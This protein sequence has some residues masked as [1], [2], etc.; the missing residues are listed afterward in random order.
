MSLSGIAEVVFFLVLIFPSYPCSWNKGSPW[1]S[2]CAAVFTFSLHPSL[3][4]RRWPLPKSPMNSLVCL[5]WC[6]TNQ[7][8]DNAS[9]MYVLFRLVFRLKIVVGCMQKYACSPPNPLLPC[10]NYHALMKFWC[11]PI[12]VQAL[13]IFYILIVLLPF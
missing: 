5:I 13:R 12:W 2:S 7:A 1:E 10:P 6:T 4:Q 11:D 3:P 9:C 8:L